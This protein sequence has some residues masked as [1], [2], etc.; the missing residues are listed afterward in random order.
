[1]YLITG[2]LGLIKSSL[3]TVFIIFLSSSCIVTDLDAPKDL[4]PLGQTDNSVTLEWRN[5]RADVDSYRVKYSPISGG[6]HGEEV[7][8]RGSGGNTQAT[9]TG[10]GQP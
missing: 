10:E 6:S 1:M 3:S 4:Q 8:P 9:I 2:T 5:S 7:F